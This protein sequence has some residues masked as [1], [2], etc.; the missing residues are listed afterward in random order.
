MSHSFIQMVDYL[1]EPYEII[2]APLWWHMQGLS[3]TTSGY[4]AKLNSGR[5]VRLPDGRTRRIYITQFS[6]AGSAWVILDKKR[7]YLR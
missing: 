5:I 7:L 6:N 4:G 1:P 3:Q 2:D